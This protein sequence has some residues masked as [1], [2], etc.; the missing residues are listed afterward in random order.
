VEPDDDDPHRRRVA[1]LTLYPARLSKDAG[2]AVGNT[3]S[4]S[5]TVTG[6][7]FD[8]VTLHGHLSL[9][10]FSDMEEVIQVKWDNF[11]ELSA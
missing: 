9:S 11:G 7:N 1:A 5:V 6:P 10:V 2:L 8:A 3:Y 4:V